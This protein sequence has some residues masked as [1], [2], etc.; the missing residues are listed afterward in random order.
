VRITGGNARGRTL[1]APKSGQA[2]I[3]PTTDRVREALFN[4]L[5]NRMTGSFVLDLFAGTGAIGIE[6]LS[7]G[8]AFT[9]FVDQSIE[10]GRLIETNLRTCF[11][12]PHAAFLQFDLAAATHLLPLLS[13]VPP[14]TRFDLVFMDPPYQ[15]NLA[16]HVLTMV[17]K[18]DFLAPS[19]LVI[20][21]EHRRVSLPAEV[22]SLT[23]ID[24][25]R[26]GETGLWFYKQQEFTSQS[27]E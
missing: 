17:E 21:E 16:E 26:Y 8:A 1:A 24:Q 23:V 4:I 14:A 15:K 20:V 13:R 2:L 10:A 6:A 7:R 25:R 3:R 9:L 5:S 18:A 19:A 22:G 27:H 11:G 12:K